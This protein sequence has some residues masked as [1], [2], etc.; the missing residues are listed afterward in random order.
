[1]Q[2]VLQE[3]RRVVPQWRSIRS[4]F[5]SNELASPGPA[6]QPSAKIVVQPLAPEF[7]ERLENFRANPDLIAAAE[8]VESA[9][10]VGQEGEA[11]NAARILVGEGSNAVPL[12]RSQAARLLQRNGAAA[13]VP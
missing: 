10:I 11:R 1:M 3:L 4:V 9:I 7:V 6:P 12:L 2:N 8:L 13:D 5:A